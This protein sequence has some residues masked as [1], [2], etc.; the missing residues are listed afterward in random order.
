MDSLSI[1]AMAAAQVQQQELSQSLEFSPN[2]TYG[3]NT[4]QS[5]FIIRKGEVSD[6]PLLRDVER[7]AGNRYRTVGLDFVAESKYVDPERLECMADANHLWVA[8]EKN[9]LIGFICGEEMDGNFHIVEISVSHEYQGQGIGKGLM[10][11]MLEQ[12]TQ[13]RSFKS[14]TLT[15]Y[16]SLS[17]NGPWYSRLGFGEVHPRLLGS[18]YDLILEIEEARHGFNQQERCLMMKDLFY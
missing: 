1:L 12:I 7:S 13:E 9:G 14:V 4:N 17:W 3:L 5:K 10:T 16:R 15:T 11:A 6:I 8:V 18:A 2:G